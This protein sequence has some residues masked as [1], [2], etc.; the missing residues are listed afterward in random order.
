MLW[1]NNRH[2]LG[3]FVLDADTETVWNL[4]LHSAFREGYYEDGEGQYCHPRAL[5]EVT[6]TPP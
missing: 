3:V 1:G 2:W 6:G 5:K 4:Q